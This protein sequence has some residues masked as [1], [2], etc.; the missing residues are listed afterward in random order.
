MGERRVYT[1]FY[2]WWFNQT[3]SIFNKFVCYRF[4]NCLRG[5]NYKLQF[6]HDI[7]NWF[8]KQCKKLF[9]THLKVKT[10]YWKLWPLL[11]KRA[12][13]DLRSTKLFLLLLH[14]AKLTG[15]IIL[16]IL[17][18]LANWMPGNQ[19]PESKC[20]FITSS[21]KAGSLTKKQKTKRRV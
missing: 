19:M 5:G 1:R 4:N 12:K 16:S 9:W 21:S 13:L 14:R 18:F 11:D 15:S 20:L 8:F 3:L 2:V 10:L 7:E 17:D 6:Y